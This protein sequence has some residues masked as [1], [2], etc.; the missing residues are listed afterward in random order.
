MYSHFTDPPWKQNLTEALYSQY[1]YIH[2]IYNLNWIVCASQ[3]IIN[4]LSNQIYVPR[5]YIE[6]AILEYNVVVSSKA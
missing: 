3:R 4:L 6:Y 5:Y 2:E 1:I